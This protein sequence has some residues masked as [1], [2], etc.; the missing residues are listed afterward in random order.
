MDQNHPPV[1]SI[2][3]NISREKS[4]LEYKNGSDNYSSANAEKINAGSNSASLKKPGHRA[5]DSCRRRK[6]KCDGNKP[7]CGRCLRDNFKCE[8]CNGRA[9]GRPP[10]SKPN[11]F[12]LS[13][14]K[15]I[16]YQKKKDQN[17]T[18]SGQGKRHEMAGSSADLIYYDGLS[19]TQYGHNS[20][21]AR[22]LS[23][24]AKS[25]DPVREIRNSSA[26]DEGIRGFNNEEY[27]SGKG[28]PILSK[29]NKCIIP[30]RSFSIFSSFPFT[31]Q[32]S[33]N[34]RL[35]SP[36]NNNNN[37]EI[38]GSNNIY[39]GQQKGKI[40]P[41]SI[42][43]P[44]YEH[45]SPQ[46]QILKPAVFSAPMV[47]EEY[48]NSS[49]FTVPTSMG[50]NTN[51]SMFTMQNAAVENSNSGLYSIQNFSGGDGNSANQR[52]DNGL[53]DGGSYPYPDLLK[54]YNGLQ[55]QNLKRG[56]DYEVNNDNPNK[57]SRRDNF[58]TGGGYGYTGEEVMSLGENSPF[59]NPS[60]GAKSFKMNDVGIGGFLDTQNEDRRLYDS[61]S[62]GNTNKNSSHLGSYN[63]DSSGIKDT[64]SGTNNG[65]GS[66]GYNENGM[67][68]IDRAV[69]QKE[70]PSSIDLLL[71]ALKNE[72]ESNTGNKGENFGSDNIFVTA[73]ISNKGQIQSPPK[74]GTKGYE[75][76][77]FLKGRLQTEN[78]NLFN[79][80]NS[81]DMKEYYLPA[82]EITNADGS[83]INFSNGNDESFRGG[84]DEQFSSARLFADIDSLVKD[85]GA[86]VT[87]NTKTIDSMNMF[88]QLPEARSPSKY[89]QY[90]TG[91]N[92]SNFGSK[93]GSMNRGMLER[94]NLAVPTTLK[95][96]KEYESILDR[97]N[98]TRQKLMFG[99]VSPSESFHGFGSGGNDSP[100]IGSPRSISSI[101]SELIHS[102]SVI[103]RSTNMYRS[104][105]FSC[106]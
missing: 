80:S 104:G 36:E 69:L 56:N 54:K 89:A 97:S 28:K 52:I 47:L 50:G 67:E 66:T 37:Q 40:V 72:S 12:E 42:Y 102:N 75:E 59:F 23:E 10:S 93:Y 5:C 81:S 21:V 1:I 65:F 62:P 82:F 86:N 31:E 90:G 83:E 94:A 106:Q 98:S 85:Q 64:I 7:S 95:R 11:S 22:L 17:Y 49:L 9:R 29:A 8:Y 45:Y 76:S 46:S 92:N 73:N 60:G 55:E 4:K 79:Q 96:N 74:N 91:N 24:S 33:N 6:T 13:T 58:G 39:P 84:D 15:K 43:I 51:S 105:Y 14:K 48:S 61:M 26:P 18:I 103:E 16:S 38:Y 27:F 99:S 34:Y 35:I 78:E 20:L 57:F 88:S 63:F 71:A 77:L 41:T 3:P 32:S 53:Q 2:M 30:R 19:S 68:R 70:D 101:H 87:P 25:A 44:G 100:F